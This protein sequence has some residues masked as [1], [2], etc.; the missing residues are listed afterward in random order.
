MNKCG[1][2]GTFVL[3]FIL[4]AF[5]SMARAD[6]GWP[7]KIQTEQGIVTLSKAPQR[8]VSTSLTLTGSLL[9]IDAPVIASGATAPNS[10]LSDDQGFF[11][12]WGEVAK[13]R[14]VKRLYIGE[15]SAE[16]V[17]AEA[18]DLIIVSATGNDSAIKLVSQLSAIAPTL[19]INYDDKS[20]QDL[21]TLLGDATGHEAQAAQRI[22]AFDDREAALKKAITLP[23]QP[24]SAMV[25]NG[26]GRAVNLWTAESAQ[27]K[28]LQQLGFTLAMPPAN[29]QQS[30]SMGQRKDIIQ[31]SGETVASGLTGHSFL[32]FAADDKT[33]QSVLSNPFLAQNEAVTHKQVYALGADTF[34]LDYYSASNLLARLE[35]LFVKS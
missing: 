11:R 25:W 23:P 8:I 3:L 10:R 30:H 22:K 15:P 19:V 6:Q 14:G 34:R 2:W 12:Q 28:L 7:R 17:A 35:K 33:A 5:S 29:I 20:W 4:Q 32:L 16:A 9:A 13:Q 24:V 1:L 27:G 21:V 26:D 18:P 31:L